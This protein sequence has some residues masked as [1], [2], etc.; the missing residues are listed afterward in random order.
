MNKNLNENPSQSDTAMN[1]VTLLDGNK[2]SWM[3]MSCIIC[4]KILSLY[5]T[6]AS[7]CPFSKACRISH[8]PNGR[9]RMGDP[10]NHAVVKVLD[11]HLIFLTHLPYQT[12]P[13]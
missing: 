4:S 6:M 9:K 13:V 8:D 5:L 7:L 2:S 12:R 10:A 3:C 11:Y 1:W